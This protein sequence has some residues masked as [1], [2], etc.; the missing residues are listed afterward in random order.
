MNARYFE[1][2]ERGHNIRCKLYREGGGSIHRLVIFFHGFAGHKENGAAEKFAARVLPKYHGTALLI[3]D[4]P[5]HGDDVKKKL[6]LGD[7]MEYLQLVIAF[8]KNSLQAE[9]LYAYAVSFG[10]YLVLRYLSQYGN[11]F[12]KV[13]LRC[14]AINMYELL[15][16]TVMNEEE[17]LL[18]GKGKSAAAGFDRKVTVDARFLQELREAD[19]RQNEYF[20]FADD[21]LILHGTAD[22]IVPYPVAEA[23]ADANAI[24][25]LSVPGGDHRFLNPLHLEAVTKAVIGFFGFQN[26]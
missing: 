5:S 17:R 8:A 18:I 21:L 25:L 22:E 9:E 10:G 26:D 14:P 19:L 7:C 13:A 3:F 4:L 15:W 11:P 24:E 16:N 6:V 2:N 20:D 23:F 12:R 1:I